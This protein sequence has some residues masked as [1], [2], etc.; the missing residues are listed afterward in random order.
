MSACRPLGYSSELLE[1]LRGRGSKVRSMQSA[2]SRC[3]H[4]CMV[5]GVDVA[6][7]QN[8]E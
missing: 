3:M 8:A 7:K 1:Y 2:Q 6:N 5:Y 4:R